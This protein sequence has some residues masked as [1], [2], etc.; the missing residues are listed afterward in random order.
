M[1]R[2]KGDQMYVVSNIYELR[3]WPLEYSENQLGL[4]LS[5]HPHTIAFPILSRDTRCGLYYNILAI[6][7][8]RA[9]RGPITCT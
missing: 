3:T 2:P 1:Y 8:R 4:L 9:E 5:R 6:S 7:N